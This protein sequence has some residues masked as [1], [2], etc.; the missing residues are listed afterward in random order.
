MFT[1]TSQ[2]MDRSS[3]SIAK[4]GSSCMRVSQ[5]FPSDH[6]IDGDLLFEDLTNVVSNVK[7]DI[8]HSH[9]VGTTLTMR[10]ALGKRHKIPRVF[11]VPGPLHLEHPFFRT[12]EIRSAGPRDSWIGSCEWTCNRYRQSGI[13]KERLYL[14]YYGTDLEEIQRREPGKLR[15]ELGIADSTRIVGMVAYMYAP[16]RY[17]GQKRGTQGTRRLD[18]RPCSSSGSGQGRGWGIHR[19]RLGWCR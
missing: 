19:W 15:T 5:A 10:M 16:K 1:S 11:Q 4:P 17:L 9:F 2:D 14:S 18:R 6:H 8:I 13:P 3:H 7:P 12:M